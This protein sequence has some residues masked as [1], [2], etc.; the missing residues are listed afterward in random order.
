MLKFFTDSY[1]LFL[2]EENKVRIWDIAQGTLVAQ[3]PSLS[4][5]K[6]LAIYRNMLAGCFNNGAVSLW[7]IREI[8]GG[9]ESIEIDGESE[10]PNISIPQPEVIQCRTKSVFR[11]LYKDPSNL[12]CLGKD[13]SSNQ[14]RV[15][16]REWENLTNI[17]SNTVVVY[18]PPSAPALS[19]EPIQP[20]LPVPTEVA[21]TDTNKFTIK[22]ENPEEETQEQEELLTDPLASSSP[23]NNS[24]SSPNNN[25]IKEETRDFIEE[26]EGENTNNTITSSDMEF[27]VDEQMLQSLV[28]GTLL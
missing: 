4:H 13:P 14:K 25:S 19:I 28:D 20:L 27:E 22:I 17:K 18:T 16:I 15:V 21:A 1:V 23:I 26:T 24:S 3:L 7:N 8:I 2:G 5:C 9:E 10:I 11:L 12:Y 6:D